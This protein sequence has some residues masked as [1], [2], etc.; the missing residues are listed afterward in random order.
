RAAFLVNAVAGTT[1]RVKFKAAGTVDSYDS[2][3]GDYSSQTPGYS[4]IITSGSTSISSATVQLTNAQSK[5]YVTTLETGPSYSSSAKLIG[6]T[7]PGTTRIDLAR[8]STSPYQ[9]QFDE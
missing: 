9:P 5:G 2:T 4:A 3:L 1:G 7:T 8:I 6:P